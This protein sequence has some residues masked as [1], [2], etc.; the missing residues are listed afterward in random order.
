MNVSRG[1]RQNVD[2]KHMCSKTESVLALDI[3]TDRFACQFNIKFSL[4][5]PYYWLLAEHSVEF[6]QGNI[7]SLMIFFTLITC[8]VDDNV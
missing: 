5:Y 3:T 6:N 8:L 7:V 4:K 2:M 1:K